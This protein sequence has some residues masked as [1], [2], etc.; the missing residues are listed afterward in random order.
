MEFQARWHLGMLAQAEIQHEPH[1]RQTV[2]GAIPRRAERLPSRIVPVTWPADTWARR[3]AGNAAARQ[4]PH[5][6]PDPV[7][8]RSNTAPVLKEI[9]LVDPEVG[10]VGAVEAALRLAGD[11]EICTNFQSARARLLRRPPDLLITNLRLEAYNGLH[12]VLLAAG[13]RTRC[14]VFSTYEDVGLAR[15]VRATGAFFE[16]SDRLPQVLESYVNATLP[17][18]DRRDIA[19]LGQ[20]LRGGRRCTDR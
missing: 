8:M 20:P 2:G 18:H 10:G 3:A 16:L 19:T 9:L 12:L 15:E 1:R 6:D 11:V 13:T 14:I 17:S 7:P 5:T 4:L